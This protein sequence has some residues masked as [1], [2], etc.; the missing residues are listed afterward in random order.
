MPAASAGPGLEQ[1][2]LDESERLGDGTTE[3]FEAA[4]HQTSVVRRSQASGLAV[5]CDDFGGELA[6]NHFTKC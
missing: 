3:L 4:I 6:S 5:K 2:M 1:V